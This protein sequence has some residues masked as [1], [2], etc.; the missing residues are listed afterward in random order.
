MPKKE[1]V[2]TSSETDV[3]SDYINNVIDRVE[4]NRADPS[5]YVK[6]TIPDDVV[7]YQFVSEEDEE[8]GAE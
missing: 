8:D 4:K 1:I 2:D 6:N 5:K 7:P 3:F